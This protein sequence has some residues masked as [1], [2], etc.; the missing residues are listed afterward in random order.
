VRTVLAVAPV[1]AVPDGRRGNDLLSDAA[2]TDPATAFGDHGV[3]F[4][5]RIDAVAADCEIVHRR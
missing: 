4:A 5:D 3:V 2:P 1:I